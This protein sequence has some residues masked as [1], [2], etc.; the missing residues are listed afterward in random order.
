MFQAIVKISHLNVSP[1]TARMQNVTML[2]LC[3]TTTLYLFACACPVSSNRSLINYPFS[4]IVCSRTIVI[5]V[6]KD[7]TILDFDLLNDAFS[8]HTGWTDTL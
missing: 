3:L 7:Y 5:F 4:C 1:S 2:K 6:F 8:A